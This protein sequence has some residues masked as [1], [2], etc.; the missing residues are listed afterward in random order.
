MDHGKTK[1]YQRNMCFCYIDYSKAFDCVDHELM[2]MMVREMGMSENLV[3]VI[4]NPLCTKQE[5]A[6][7][8]EYGETEWFGIAKGVDGG[9]FSSLTYSIRIISTS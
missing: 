6:G 1:E 4:R 3:R 2:W 5:A 9:T 8:T 7:R